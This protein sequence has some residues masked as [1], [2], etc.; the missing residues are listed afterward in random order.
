LKTLI[1]VG[2]LAPP[3][4][5]RMRQLQFF[6]TSLLGL[7]FILGGLMRVAA[8]PPQA[9]R[10]E[11]DSLKA[12]LLQGERDT[13]TVITAKRLAF[14]LQ[15]I[16][17]NEAIQ[18]GQQSLD[19]ARELGYQRG[20]MSGLLTLG[21]C[22]MA[23]GHLDLALEHHRQG[24]LVALE[25]GNQ[26]GLFNAFMNAGSTFELKGD[27][28]KAVK[29]LI[30]AR[31]IADEMGDEENVVDCNFNLGITYFRLRN[32]KPALEFFT[33]AAE[34]AKASGNLKGY[35]ASLDAI[36]NVYVKQKDY[37][38]ALAIYEQA[39]EIVLPLEDIADLAP[40][41]A[42]IG[43][44]YFFK[45]DY[46]KAV[47][48]MQK[49]LQLGLETGQMGLV[50][51]TYSNLGNCYR[52]MGNHELAKANSIQALEMAKEM[53][54]RSTMLV[55][56]DNLVETF[57]KTGQTTEALNY[58]REL[59]ALKDSL[60]VDEAA[61][62]IANILLAH[63]AEKG[64]QNLLLMAEQKASAESRAEKNK[65]WLVA[66]FLFAALLLITITLLILLQRSRKHAAEAQLAQK[67]AEFAA[68]KLHLE[69]RAL[70]AQMNPH[71]IFNSLNA[72]QR[73]YIEGDMERAGDYMADFARLL[74]KILDHSGNEQITVAEELDTLKLYINLE[75]A[76]L[77]DQFE[78]E[79]EVDPEL[80]T[81][82]TYLPPLVIQ[83]FLE[84]AIWHG[85]APKPG[86]GLI[87]VRLT[88]YEGE[89]AK[90]PMIVCTIEDD[91]IGI[92][93]SQRN[94]KDDGHRSKGMRITQE[95][96]GT[97]GT[98]TTAELTT[99]GTR[100][101]LTIPVEFE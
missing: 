82:N 58:Y 9:Q 83:P 80:D 64:E 8:M 46:P 55:A 12:I 60:Q 26:R 63:E 35:A 101:V 18:Y 77:E 43:S 54:N 88:P 3:K 27:Y 81:N 94:K 86:K 73:M 49:G 51:D 100:I 98:M 59:S 96:L 68:K 44:V 71:F 13:N 93:T 97:D 40:K 50:A 31:R 91:G 92:E 4:Q 78:F 90:Q 79:I 69:Q 33:A 74:R 52:L 17:T 21:Q 45:E 22:H 38:K 84:N 72:I 32:Y 37:D 24:G 25:L 7:A 19:L 53:D 34:R 20:I 11:V 1:F 47:H 6:W 89:S 56:L 30:E 76:R 87:K 70:R 75:K 95:R 10:S 62:E 28:R 67:E 23:A 65:F 48:Y 42:N 39:V 36:G 14:R 16:N 61:A 57:S 29:A 5:M 2:S 66:A 15:F 41:Y 99:G 85:I